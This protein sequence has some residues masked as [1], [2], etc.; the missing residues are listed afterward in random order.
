M[1][2]RWEIASIAA[3]VILLAIGLAA[4]AVFL[5]QRKAGDRTVIY[6][7][8]FAIP[9]AIRLLIEQ[10]AM[11]SGLDLPK[12]ERDHIHVALT[13]L[14]PVPFLLYLLQILKERGS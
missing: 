3:G 8:L 1:K 11:L 5:F 13:L 9:Y 14:I 6:F 12:T 2:L 10:P 4:V 7:G